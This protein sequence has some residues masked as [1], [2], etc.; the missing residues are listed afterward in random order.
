MFSKVVLYHRGTMLHGTLAVVDWG[1]RA[2][3]V[4]RCHWDAATDCAAD[5]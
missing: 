2:G 5:M 1:R 4:C 3:H